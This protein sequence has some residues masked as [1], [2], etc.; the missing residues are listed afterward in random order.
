[1]SKNIIKFFHV[2]IISSLIL[3]FS[4]CGYKGPPKYMDSSTQASK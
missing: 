2:I 4:A 1:M 3:G